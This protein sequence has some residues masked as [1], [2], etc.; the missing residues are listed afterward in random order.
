MRSVIVFGF[1]NPGR[2]DDGLG[3]ALAD[4]LEKEPLP[5]VVPDSDY[6]LNVEDGYTISEHDAVVFV[7]A[8]VSCAEPFE[9]CAIEPSAEITFT[10]HAIS[11]E[12]VLALCHDLYNPR[13]KGYVLAI[14]GYDF[15]LVEELTTRAKANLDAAYGFLRETLHKMV[16]EDGAAVPLSH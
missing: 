12:S 6:Q 1:G 10:T 16:L 9:F 8:S 2:R 15:E 14:R 4:R 3:P 7:D 11:P 13:V 5:G